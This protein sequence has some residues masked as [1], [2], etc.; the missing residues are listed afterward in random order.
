MIHKCQHYSM[1]R[2]NAAR[3]DTGCVYDSLEYV[4]AGQKL[5]TTAAA[6]PASNQ[7]LGRRES[8]LGAWRLRHRPSH[9]YAQWDKASIPD[10]VKFVSAEL[11]TEQKLFQSRYLWYLT[12]QTTITLLFF[13][14]MGPRLPWPALWDPSQLP[15]SKLTLSCGTDLIRSNTSLLCTSCRL[16]RL[17]TQPTGGRWL[18]RICTAGSAFK[19]SMDHSVDWERPT[20]W[21]H[22]LIIIIIIIFY[23][24]SNLLTYR[25]GTWRSSQTSNCRNFSSWY[26]I[27]YVK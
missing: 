2:E 8:G 6:A 13:S 20:C 14:G 19:G 3:P 7:A 17:R 11:S 5:Q 27:I 18:W 26:I 24:S 12:K 1:L 10:H 22:M 4:P 23:I 21:P 9:Y 16:R 15:V 25:E